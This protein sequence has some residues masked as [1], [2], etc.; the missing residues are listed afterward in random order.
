MRRKPYTARGIVRV[1]CA[2]CGKP[3]R[4]QWQIC[5]DDNTWRGLCVEC[6]VAL[7]AMVLAF[8][9]DPWADVKMAAY[10]IRVR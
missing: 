6:D 8:I 3:S 1:P 9:G 2:K 10:R 7:N 4:Y 5:A